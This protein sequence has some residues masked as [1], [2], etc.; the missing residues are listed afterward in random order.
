MTKILDYQGTFKSK[1]LA[2]QLQD[3]LGWTP[4]TAEGTTR[5]Q[6]RDGEVY[7]YA[8]DDTPEQDVQA[9]IDAHDPTEL[10]Q[11]EI[12]TANREDARARFLASQLADKTPE[13]IFTL[14]QARMDSWSSLADARADLREWI[15]LLAA[16]IAWKVV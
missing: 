9:V 7:V 12:N 15:P 6:S 14:M 16:I 11:G 2:D 1:L 5:L 4:V 10:T 3:A 8:D 13:E